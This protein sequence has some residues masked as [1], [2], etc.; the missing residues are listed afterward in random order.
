MNRYITFNVEQ[1]M[2]DSSDWKSK[3]EGLYAELESITEIRGASGETHSCGSISNPTQNTALRRQEIEEKIQRIE[4]YQAAFEFAWDRISEYDR[5]M[6]TGFF[7][8]PG[9][10]YEFVRIWCQDKASNERYCYRDRNAALNHFRVQIEK[11]MR[12]HGYD[13]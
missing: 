2:R 4:D 12:K 1:F 8:A 10:I 6:I 13:V 7:F 3:L 9:P 11:W 5:E